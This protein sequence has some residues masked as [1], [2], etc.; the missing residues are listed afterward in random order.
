M[1]S[2]NACTQL[3]LVLSPTRCSQR[4]VCTG[5]QM[6]EQHRP[7]CPVSGCG[8][9]KGNLSKRGGSK[10]W[11]YSVDSNRHLLVGQLDEAL[12]ALAAVRAVRTAAN[13][14]I[15]RAGG[16]CVKED[17]KEGGEYGGARQTAAGLCRDGTEEER[18][19]RGAAG[20]RQR[21]RR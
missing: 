4:V 10:R 18:A 15:E 12:D 11:W 17:E 21:R 5:M 14:R 13:E 20:V 19:V 6:A 9:W 1:N 3:L 16:E 8:V 2:L 7:R